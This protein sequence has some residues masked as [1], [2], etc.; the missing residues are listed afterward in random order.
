MPVPRKKS[1]QTLTAGGVLGRGPI[2]GTLVRGSPT[3]SVV[4][5]SPILSSAPSGDMT[6]APPLLRPGASGAL[7]GVGREEDGEGEEGAEGD[8][9]G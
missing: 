1:V 4:R 6:I 8:D 7:E 3:L 2:P 9:A 5:D